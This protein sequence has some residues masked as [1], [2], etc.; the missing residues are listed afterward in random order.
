MCVTKYQIYLLGCCCSICY[1]NL[2]KNDPLLRILFSLVLLTY[3][4]TSRG[5]VLPEKLTSIQLVKKFPAFYGTRRFI[6][7]FKRA[8]NLSL[9]WA[10]SIQSISP[11]PISCSITVPYE[12]LIGN[13]GDFSSRQNNICWLWKKLHL[14]YDLFLQICH[15]QVMPVSELRNFGRIFFMYVD[16]GS[17]LQ[18]IFGCFPFFIYL[19][20]LVSC[21]FVHVFFFY[22]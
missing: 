6:M 3:L 13:T 19:M 10:N 16:F 17:F 9:S 7:V 21:R 4:F 5:R 2:S 12:I 15:P 18:R 14:N 20:C 11:H 1:S 8:H 22:W